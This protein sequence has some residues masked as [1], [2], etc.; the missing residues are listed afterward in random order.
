MLR[1]ILMLFFLTIVK[2]QQTRKLQDIL[3]DML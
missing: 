2:L 1:S 3:A